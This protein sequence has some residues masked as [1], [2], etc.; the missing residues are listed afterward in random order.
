MRVVGMRRLG[1][2]ELLEVPDPGDPGPGEVRVAVEMVALS[3]AEVRAVRGDRFRHFG[4][5][6]DPDDPFVFGFAGVGRVESSADSSL[7]PGTRVV[8][9]GLETCGVC[10]FCADDRENHCENLKLSGIDVGC[11]GFARERVVL[12]ARRAFALPESF[13]AEIAC[14][15]SEVATAI[16]ALR[17]GR[18]QSGDSI[19][20]VGTGRHGRQFIRVAKRWGAHVVAID[21]SEASLVLARDAGA[22]ET[23]SPDDR[24]DRD[25]DVV[26]HANSD[27]SSLGL[28]CDIAAPGGRVILLGTPAGLDVSLSRAGERVAGMEREL[29]GTDAKTAAGYVSAIELM[30]TGSEDWDIRRPKRLKITEA[31]SALTAAAA[32]WPPA[33]DLFISIGAAAK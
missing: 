4:Q 5:V 29:I 26:V 22:D 28:C 18:L 7:A 25:L 10:A 3:M 21:P 2:P 8:L 19:G 15:V 24:S 27:E 20:I 16:H 32:N 13:P 17:R 30:S 23:M 12:P 1:E 14:V 31:A 11:P 33:N 6:V 9:S